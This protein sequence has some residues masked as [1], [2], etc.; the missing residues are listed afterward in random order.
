MVSF[1]I[2]SFNT[3]E[4]LPLLIP[5]FQGSEGNESLAAHLRPLWERQRLLRGEGQEEEPWPGPPWTFLSV[6][7]RG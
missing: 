2:P 4:T 5:A 6:K 1:G 3:P 7:D